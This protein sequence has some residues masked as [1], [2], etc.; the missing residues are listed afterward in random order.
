V[1][2]ARRGNCKKC[3]RP[4]DEG[5]PTT[6]PRSSPAKPIAREGGGP[7][8][9]GTSLARED[10]GSEIPSTSRESVPVRPAAVRQTEGNVLAP[11]LVVDSDPQLVASYELL[12][13]A[14]LPRFSARSRRRPRYLPKNEFRWSRRRWV[15]RRK[16]PDVVR[17][18]CASHAAGRGHRTGSP[19]DGSG[20]RAFEAG[21]RLCTQAI[22]PGFAVLSRVIHIVA[23]HR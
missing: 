23:G 11:V 21:Q 14:S 17:I 15:Q 4:R 19:A 12:L 22:G 3:G 18:A 20:R 8:R 10:D 6:D 9:S 13:G 16:G 1:A 5:F 7:P 2:G